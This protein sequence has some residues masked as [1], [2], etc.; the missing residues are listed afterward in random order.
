[1]QLVLVDEGFSQRYGCPV[2]GNI[3][4]VAVSEARPQNSFWCM[5][6]STPLFEARPCVLMPLP[7]QMEVVCYVTGTGKQ[8]DLGV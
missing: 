6:G 4:E 3:K 7:A 2:C 1:M 5:H 8:L